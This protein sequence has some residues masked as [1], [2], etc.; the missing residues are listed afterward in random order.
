MTDAELS[1]LGSV[2]FVVGFS[3]GFAYALIRYD[4]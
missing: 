2:Y 3:I 1:T 4:R